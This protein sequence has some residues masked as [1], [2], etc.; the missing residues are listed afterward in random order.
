MFVHKPWARPF[1]DRVYLVEKMVA[2]GGGTCGHNDHCIY[3][4]PTGFVDWV[5][6]TLFSLLLTE[7]ERKAPA[8]PV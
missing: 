7:R 1:D 6:R 3:P 8:L 2:G 5:R 4:F